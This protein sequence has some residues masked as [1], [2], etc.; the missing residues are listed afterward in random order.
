[1][2]RTGAGQGSRR[3][4]GKKVN[5]RHARLAG[6]RGSLQLHAGGGPPARTG[7]GGPPRA[8]RLIE[9]NVRS[10]DLTLHIHRAWRKRQVDDSIVDD[11]ITGAGRCG[12]VATATTALAVEPQ[13]CA[14]QSRRAGM[15]GDMPRTRPPADDA[16][17]R[18][19]TANLGVS[20]LACTAADDEGQ[21]APSQ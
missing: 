16:R 1:V 10:P 17:A 13:G 15:Q 18:T 20:A 12:V 7:N 6:A 21:K 9:I 5:K 19:A 4:S 11:S 8:L 14:L 3:L 2:A